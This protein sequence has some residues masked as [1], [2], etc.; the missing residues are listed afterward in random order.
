MNQSLI[1]PTVYRNTNDNRPD[2]FI[3]EEFNF[4]NS[5]ILFP[6]YNKPVIKYNSV[7]YSK[8]I[9]GGFSYGGRVV[10][11]I[12]NKIHQYYNNIQLY[13]QFCK[14]SIQIYT[15][16]TIFKTVNIQ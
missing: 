13:S 9:T 16:G 14:S 8:L 1:Q 2:P 11:T 5:L 10:N 15:F 6:Q 4:I 7:I 12:A 3:E